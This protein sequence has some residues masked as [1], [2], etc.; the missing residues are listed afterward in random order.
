M[1][2]KYSLLLLF[3]SFCCLGVQCKKDEKTEL[4]KLPPITAVGAQTFGCLINGEAFV[5]GEKDILS[6][7]YKDGLLL[8]QAQQYSIT[9]N[10][11][12]VALNIDRFIY[13][14]GH[15]KVPYNHLETN[16]YVSLPDINSSFFSDVFDTGYAIINIHRFDTVNYYIAGTFEFVAKEAFNKPI[17]A[18]V[19]QGRFD[20]K[21]Q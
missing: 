20:L 1:K 17:Y 13:G 3:A 9:G 10:S 16:F 4:E 12:K 8:I 5:I 15:Y 6:A 7:I 18:I 2:N 11:K 21:Y 14:V 19:Q